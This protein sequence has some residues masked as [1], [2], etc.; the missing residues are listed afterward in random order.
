MLVVKKVSEK[1]DKKFTVFDHA[2]AWNYYKIR[3]AEEN[4]IQCDAKYVKWC[5]LTKCYLYSD[6]WVTFLTKELNQPEKYN[7]IVKQKII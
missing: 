3:P 5:D 7:K 2:T 4:S 6:N 1:I